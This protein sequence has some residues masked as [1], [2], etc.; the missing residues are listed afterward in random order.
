MVLPASMKTHIPGS[1]SRAMAAPSAAFAS[2]AMRA[3]ALTLP[4][5][6]VDGSAPP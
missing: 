3:R 6:G 1:T 4:T 5:A 2:G